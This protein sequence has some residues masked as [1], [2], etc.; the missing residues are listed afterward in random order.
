MNTEWQHLLWTTNYSWMQIMSSI[1]LVASSVSPKSP[2]LHNVP[3]N[4]TFHE[5]A[6]MGN[7]YVRILI[8]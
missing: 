1:Q 7:V 6:E 4:R 2:E 5:T 3:D 8:I